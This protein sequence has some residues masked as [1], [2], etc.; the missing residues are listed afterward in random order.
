MPLVYNTIQEVCKNYLTADE[1]EHFNSQEYFDSQPRRPHTLNPKQAVWFGGNAYSGDAK[2]FRGEITPIE[3][4]GMSATIE[5]QNG[6]WVLTLNVSD[7]V[8][9]A[10]CEQITTEMLGMPVFSEERYENPD[11]SDVDLTIDLIGNKRER[12]IPG[13]IA[14]LKCGE[15]RITVWKL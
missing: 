12:V 15:Q 10:S 1:Y 8:A 6:E 4:E 5:N 14:S 9:Q 3:S 2:P 13:A 7:A 11:G